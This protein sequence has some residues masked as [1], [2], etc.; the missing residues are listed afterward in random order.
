MKLSKANRRIA[1]QSVAT[2]LKLF[3]RDPKLESG[4]RETPARFI[5]MLE[6]LHTPRP[7]EFTFFDESHSDEMLFVGKIPFTSSCEHHLA[8]FT[9]LA[10]VAYIPIAQRIVGISKLPSCVAARAA[11]FQ[12]QERITRRVA[13][14][15]VRAIDLQIK[16]RSSEDLRLRGFDSG[17]PYYQHGASVAVMLCARHSCMEARGAKAHGA[18]T[19]TTALTGQFK[20][21]PATRAEFLMKANASMQQMM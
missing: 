8:L 16:F 21:D 5:K 19:I 3:G 13:D 18:V 10:A 17:H 20:H 14:D 2:I 11:G 6:E 9:G 4:L 7:F 15:L 1:Q 12:N